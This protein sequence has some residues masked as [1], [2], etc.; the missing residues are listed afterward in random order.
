MIRLKTDGLKLMYKK[1]QPLN[2]HVVHM[3]LLRACT[4]E[5]ITKFSDNA[6][7]IVLSWH[8]CGT[9][10]HDPVY[11]LEPTDSEYDDP[12]LY[13]VLDTFFKRKEIIEKKD[14]DIPI[15]KR[16]DTETGVVSFFP[17][18][19]KKGISTDPI[20]RISIKEYDNLIERVVKP[21]SD[22]ILEM[23]LDAGE[24]IKTDVLIWAI[25]FRYKYLG[26]GNTHKSYNGYHI[27]KKL[28]K[29]I[30][31]IIGE[32]MDLFG[33][34][35][36][37]MNN[38]ISPY[39]C[40][41]FPDIEQYF[42][43]VGNCFDIELLSGSYLCYPPSRDMGILKAL[44]SKYDEWLSDSKI[45]I[46]IITPIIDDDGLA[47]VNKYEM[48]HHYPDKYNWEHLRFETLPDKY[49]ISDEF[50]LLYPR[51]TLPFMAGETSV[52]NSEPIYISIH[53]GDKIA[54]GTPLVGLSKFIN[55][56]PPIPREKTIKK[57]IGGKLPKT[58]KDLVDAIDKSKTKKTAK[59]KKASLA[60]FSGE[61]NMDISVISRTCP[62]IPKT[63]YGIDTAKYLRH[64]LIYIPE[65]VKFR[66][67]YIHI[68]EIN[69]LRRTLKDEMKMKMLKTTSFSIGPTKADK[70]GIYSV[71]SKNIPPELIDLIIQQIPICQERDY[72]GKEYIIQV[73]N[74]TDTE[75]MIYTNDIKTQK[76]GSMVTPTRMFNRGFT[77]FEL[78]RRNAITIKMEVIEIYPYVNAN[79]STICTFMPFPTCISET[80]MPSD[81]SSFD[82][83]KANLETDFVLTMVTNGGCDPFRTFKR[84]SSELIERL[85]VIK[86]LYDTMTVRDYHDRD[87]D[88]TRQE[89]RLSIPNETDT[90]GGLLQKTITKMVPDI[91]LVTYN[92]HLDLRNTDLCIM[93]LG[94]TKEQALDIISNAIDYLS[95]R[96]MSIVDNSDID[97]RKVPLVPITVK[98]T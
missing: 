73:A 36:G 86:G 67:K 17:K 95:Q 2:K 18:K 92:N 82:P 37:V 63:I 19:I 46:C 6:L 69:A 58:K 15:V 1:I 93:L 20:I 49:F 32:H 97:I 24:E 72:T 11:S 44:Q 91:P 12:K 59:M 83:I 28:R 87:D 50:P 27:H 89:Y 45:K 80:G 43:S 56:Y 71:Q 79:A 78:P 74:N 25:L 85:Q 65:T 8:L 96:F 84:A 75:M 47:L 9:P 14:T 29:N 98:A 31:K 35:Y 21:A 4:F 16:I 55:K 3:E 10:I 51:K 70:V 34:I 13:E 94:A 48:E 33:S 23:D 60:T 7:P 54:I 38:T 53:I 61:T 22:D 88:I 30:G 77:L 39:F 26:L 81:L 62:L 57:V 64:P 52:F 41:L 66:A 90:I 5:A 40:G 42:G 76:K 68:E